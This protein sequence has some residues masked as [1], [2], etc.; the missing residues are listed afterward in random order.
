MTS[1]KVFGKTIS[2][3]SSFVAVLDLKIHKAVTAT[4][5]SFLVNVSILSKITSKILIPTTKVKVIRSIYKTGR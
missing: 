3:K 2:T 4:N 1:E 5:H